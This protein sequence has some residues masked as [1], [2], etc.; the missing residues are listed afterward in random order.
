MAIYQNITQL[1]GNTPIIKL[2]NIVPEG[3]GDVYVKLEAFNPGLLLLKIVLLWQM[4]E[5][6]RK[7]GTI[8]PGDTIVEPTSGSTGNRT[9]M[10]LVWEKVIK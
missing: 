7:A 1:V 9:C 2:N 5:V 3:A 8:K 4:I 6:C 10:G